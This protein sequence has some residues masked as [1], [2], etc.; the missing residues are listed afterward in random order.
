MG[1]MIHSLPCIPNYFRSYTTIEKTIDTPSL[2]GCGGPI[3]PSH[4]QYFISDHWPYSV[5]HMF[6]LKCVEYLRHNSTFSTGTIHT[7]A[8]NHSFFSTCPLWSPM[9]VDLFVWLNCI[10][11]RLSHPK[12]DANIR[13][14]HG[15]HNPTLG[16]KT[17]FSFLG[18]LPHVCWLYLF[19]FSW[20]HTRIP[21]CFNYSN[22]PHF[23]QTLL[24]WEIQT[25]PSPLLPKPLFSIV[26]SLAAR[27]F[28]WKRMHW[29]N[30]SLKRQDQVWR[31]K[32]WYPEHS[33][34]LYTLTVRIDQYFHRIHLS[35]GNFLRRHCKPCVYWCSFYHE[36]TELNLCTW[37]VT[38]TKRQRMLGAY[39]GIGCKGSPMFGPWH[40]ASGHFIY[41]LVN[42]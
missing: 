2:E 39:D 6:V 28:R 30:I 14:Y 18:S 37:Q 16:K 34:K 1:I 12:N 38:K 4:D 24:R 33:R 26:S 31:W 32:I 36:F 5:T 22:Y 23:Y 25:A 8:Y 9:F 20:E 27:A 10:G 42:W 17:H 21:C 41:P 29:I 11:Q 13:K 40:I 35:F 19:P 15:G 3:T 7:G